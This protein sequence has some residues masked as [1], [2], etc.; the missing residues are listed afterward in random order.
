[1]GGSKGSTF[2]ERWRSADEVAHRRF[3]LKIAQAGL[4]FVAVW[5]GVGSALSAALSLPDVQRIV[6]VVAGFAAAFGVLHV[7]RGRLG[8]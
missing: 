6:G 2:L 7:L 1:M 4:V 8:R 5:I 3:T